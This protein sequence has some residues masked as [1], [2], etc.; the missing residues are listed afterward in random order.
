MLSKLKYLYWNL[1][2]YHLRPGQIWYQI[3]C[4]LWHRYTTIKP[5]TLGH[6][7]CDT[8]TLLAHITFELLTQFLEEECSPG[9][10]DWYYATDD[11]KGNKIEFNGEERWIIDV[12]REICDWWHKDYLVNVDRTYDAWHNY[13]IENKL[14]IFE[15]ELDEEDIKEGY[16]HNTPEQRQIL[17]ELF[18]KGREL[19]EYYNE[20]LT[21]Y[22]I[23]LVEIRGYLWT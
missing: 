6:T 14:A 11:Y 10:V 12:L 17:D 21:K 7:Y 16:R 8:D 19:E 5:R 20:T 4:F 13:L 3:K 15:W 1:I 23:K 18:N 9:C 2:P 22:L